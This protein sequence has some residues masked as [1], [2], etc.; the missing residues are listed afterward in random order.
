MREGSRSELRERRETD[1]WSAPDYPSHF[2]LR[3]SGKSS[4]RSVM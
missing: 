1:V 3:I 4:P 2:Q